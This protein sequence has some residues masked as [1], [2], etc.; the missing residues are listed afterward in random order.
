MNKIIITLTS[1]IAGCVPVGFLILIVS[2]IFLSGKMIDI[3]MFMFSLS[4]LLLIIILL[5]LLIKMISEISRLE[6]LEKK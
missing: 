3:G 2:Q 5:I 6:K 4:I 1:L